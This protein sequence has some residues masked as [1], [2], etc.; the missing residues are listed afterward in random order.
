MQSVSQPPLPERVG[1]GEWDRHGDKVS[2]DRHEGPQF[3]EGAF[4][5]QSWRSPGF[6]HWFLKNLKC[7]LSAGFW[8]PASLGEWKS[9]ALPQSWGEGSVG[10][11]QG[12]LA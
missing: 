9:Q 6:E 4:P 1:W 2:G 10:R 11:N 12:C 8:M 5:G 7:D 3:T